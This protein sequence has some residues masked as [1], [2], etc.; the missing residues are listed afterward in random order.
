MMF[1]HATTHGTAAA[2]QPQRALLTHR[3]HEILALIDRGLA[4]KEMPVALSISLT[5]VKNHVHH[6]LEKLGVQHRSAAAA[7]LRS[8]DPI[9][10]I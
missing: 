4:N 10:P 1:R 7:R 8:M 6:V 3:E 2:V 5:T 9:H